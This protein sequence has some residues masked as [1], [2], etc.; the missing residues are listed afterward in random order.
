MCIRDRVGSLG[1]YSFAD[2][3]VDVSDASSKGK[4]AIDNNPVIN[5]QASDGSIKAVSYTHLDV[6]K[7]QV[8]IWRI[9]LMSYLSRGL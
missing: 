3:V 9:S 6:Y 1:S 2:V 5:E 7:R 4:V 8:S